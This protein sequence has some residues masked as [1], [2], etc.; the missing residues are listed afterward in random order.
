MKNIK[1]VAITIFRSVKQFIPLKLLYLI[2]PLR[3]FLYTFFYGPQIEMVLRPEIEIRLVSLLEG[4]EIKTFKEFPNKAMWLEMVSG[5]LGEWD[6]K[7]AEVFFFGDRAF[8]PEMCLFLMKDCT[9][10][11]TA[12]GQTQ[13]N[14]GKVTG[15]LHMVSVLPEYRGLGLGR[16]ITLAVLHKLRK[17]FPDANIILKTDSWRLPAINTYKEIG[18][19]VYE[20]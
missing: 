15:I 14:S 3:E 19:S 6:E 1:R 7:S 9:V 18:F 8:D 12:S 5:S 13:K 4:F 17:R 2:Q 20:N 16:Q 10:V 11:G